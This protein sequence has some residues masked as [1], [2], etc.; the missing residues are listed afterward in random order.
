MWTGT[1]VLRCGVPRSSVREFVCSMCQV[2]VFIVAVPRYPLAFQAMVCPEDA[3]VASIWERYYKQ[4]IDNLWK[5]DSVKD[6]L[7]KT[8][9]DKADNKRQ[10]G[11]RGGGKKKRQGRT[12]PFHARNGHDNT[13]CTLNISSHSEDRIL[14]QQFL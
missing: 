12:Y 2:L 13:P 10:E 4:E 1:C 5:L 9:D 7:R 8:Q 3:G 6:M 14:A 11:T